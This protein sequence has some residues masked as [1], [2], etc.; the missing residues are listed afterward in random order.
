MPHMMSDPNCWNYTYCWRSP[1][2][3]PCASGDDSL[4]NNNVLYDPC[5]ERARKRTRKRIVAALTFLFD[6]DYVAGGR[7]Y[8]GKD[9]DYSTALLMEGWWFVPPDDDLPFFV[10]KDEFEA[11]DIV[12]ELVQEERLIASDGGV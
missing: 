9:K 5:T 12:R 11:L 3:I 1:K 8:W 2:P 4:D 6:E 7:L 10:G